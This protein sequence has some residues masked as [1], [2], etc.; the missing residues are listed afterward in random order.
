MLHA[1]ANLHGSGRCSAGFSPVLKII[2]YKNIR[3]TVV[4]SFSAH[5]ICLQAPL[6]LI[7]YAESSFR[8]HLFS[9]S[10]DSIPGRGLNPKTKANAF[11]SSGRFRLFIH[12][13]CC[14]RRDYC[15]RLRTFRQ[16]KRLFAGLLKRAAMCGTT[17]ARKQKSG[18]D[19]AK[20]VLETLFSARASVHDRQQIGCAEQRHDEARRN[21]FGRERHSADQI[22]ADEQQGADER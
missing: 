20:E 13:K 18:M 11:A 22:R 5:R 7:R 15:A 8:S 9:D 3:R 4:A 2:L 14:S 6:F 1:T 21:F 16:L 17:P 19:A 10:F 12:R